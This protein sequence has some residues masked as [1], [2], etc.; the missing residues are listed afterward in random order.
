M[1]AALADTEMDAVAVQHRFVY[2]P[3]CGPE[4]F[5]DLVTVGDTNRVVCNEGPPHGSWL[6]DGSLLVMTFHWTSESNFRALT[7]F[8]LALAT[9]RAKSEL[10]DS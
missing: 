3:L 10:P 9:A 5:L 4:I 1:Q 6:I 8:Y 7:W 2:K